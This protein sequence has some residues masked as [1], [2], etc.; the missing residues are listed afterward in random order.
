MPKEKIVDLPLIVLTGL[1]IKRKMV[2][3]ED[4]SSIDFEYDLF[5][6]FSKTSMGV[7]T[8]TAQ[9]N[10]TMFPAEHYSLSITEVINLAAAKLMFRIWPDDK[11]RTSMAMVHA[12]A[13]SISP[14]FT[15]TALPPAHGEFM[16]GDTKVL[17]QRTI[18]AGRME[19]GYSMG[20]Q[21]VIHQEDGKPDV[22]ESRGE[23]LTLRCNAEVKDIPTPEEMYLIYK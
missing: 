9:V 14:Q 1:T 18:Q 12:A 17:W 2:I 15:L 22:E 6:Q 8:S 11:D 19:T 21:V 20:E 13:K 5:N 7:L 10:S 16:D 3:A 23:F 4:N